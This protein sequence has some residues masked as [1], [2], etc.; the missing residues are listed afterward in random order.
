MEKS[1]YLEQFKKLENNKELFNFEGNFILVEKLPKREIKTKSGIILTKSSQ[2][3]VGTV[4]DNIPNFGLV[5]L[6]GEGY[7]DEAGELIKD[8]MNVKPGNVIL[9][10]EHSVVYYSYFPISDYSH[11]TIGLT[12]E[13]DFQMKFDSIEN[14]NKFLD[15]LMPEGGI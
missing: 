10:P 3:Q 1:K 15:I 14:Y 9:I 7:R 11:N 12:R 6:V 4:H 13:S 8:S 5:L 2:L